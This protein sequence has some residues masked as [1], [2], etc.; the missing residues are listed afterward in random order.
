MSIAST[1]ALALA[2]ALEVYCEAR[3]VGGG[4]GTSASSDNTEVLARESER[5][6]E[7]TNGKDDE[8]VEYAIAG[9][10]AN[11]A[12]GVS[13]SSVVASAGARCAMLDRDALRACRGS[14]QASAELAVI[15][16]LFWFCDRSGLVR[17]RT[18]S[19]DRDLLAAIFCGLAAYGWKT[20]LKDSKTSAPLHRQQ[21]EEMKGWMQV[22]FL[23]YHYFDA[24]EMYNLIRVFIAAY[25]WMTG[26]GNF[27]YYYIKNDFSA[28]R[29][30][31]MMWRLNFFVCV[32]CLVMKNDYMLYYICPM[33]TLYTLTCYCAL[34]IFKSKNNDPKWI[35]AKFA[36]SFALVAV[37]WEIPGVF[38]ALFRPFQF[39]FGYVNPARPDIPALHEWHFR[40]G[41]DRYIWI[42]GMMCA[43]WH[44]KYESMMKWIDE[45]SLRERV[46][47]QGGIVAASSAVLYA[48]FVTL[49]SLDKFAYNK[50][51]PYTSWIPL[52]CFIFLRNATKSLRSYHIDIFCICGQVTLETYICQFHIWLSTSNVPNGQPKMIMD[53]VPG[54]PLLNFLLCSYIY[55]GISH[56]VF[57]VTNVLKDS[58]IPSKDHIALTHNLIL[59][60][61][62]IAFAGAIGVFSSLMFTGST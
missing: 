9:D 52:T 32:V 29:F 58:I 62:F 44:P 31:Q 21:T 22:L 50:W 7:R 59:S 42:Y 46:I 1:L 8:D 18:K 2:F 6:I 54:Y 19:Y 16:F 35:Y 43:Y 3:D 33:H 40:S 37:V 15:M 34:A 53:L 17:E 30:A 28:I 36:V 26:F 10:R 60:G 51:H 27:S 45:R 24:G 55:I 38:D 20:S 4:Q 61:A 5:S 39:L 14:I 57:H 49:Y 13:A 56:R 48:W 41:L 23:L 12:R 47:F 25:V 11:R